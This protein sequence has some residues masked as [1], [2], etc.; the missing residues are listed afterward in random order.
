MTI[1]RSTPGRTGTRGRDRRTTPAAGRCGRAT[2]GAWRG[3]SLVRPGRPRWPGPDLAY[4]SESRD[5]GVG[6][7]ARLC[8]VNAEPPSYPWPAGSATGVGSMPGTDPAEALAVVLGELPDLPHLPELPAPRRRG[9]PDRPHRG[10]ARRHPGRDDAPRLEAGRP[11]RPRPAPGGRAC[12]P[13]TWTRCTRRP[14]TGPGRSRSRYAARGRWRPRSS[15]SRSQNPALADPGAVADLIASLAEGVA[16]HVAEVRGR[17]PGATVL[18]QLDEPALPAVLAGSVPTA[19]GLNRVG[20]VDTTV[21]GDGLRSVL[22]ATTAFGLVHCCARDLPLRIM[23]E[24]GA[25]AVG[26]DLSLLRREEEQDELA[27]VVE[28]GLGILAGV[29]QIPQRSAA[30]A[31]PSPRE[32]GA[33]V[34]E[35]WHRMGIPAGGLDRQVV[36]TP[37]CGLAGASPA[38]ARAAL[39]RC[40]EA[41]RLLPELIEEG[42]GDDASRAGGGP[43][44]PAAA[45]RAGRRD[46]RA[47][48]PLPRA[49]LAGHLRRR[50]RRAHARAAR[51]RGAAT[52]SCARRTRRPRRS[53]T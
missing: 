17:I 39:A 49:R 9:R 22:D 34:L 38:G 53:A 41:A 13:R 5:R 4:L 37:A 21:T 15:C 48:P 18:L 12:C 42:A 29:V 32:P 47:Q 20:A 51:A 24:A 36:L 50:V 52:R 45:R 44:G 3:R 16:A 1:R 14:R 27:E 30:G 19:S 33:E 6:G 35:L 25:Q 46:H 26:F 23:K 40:R 43:G 10:A 28:A 11:A 8:C 2:T 7:P 31:P